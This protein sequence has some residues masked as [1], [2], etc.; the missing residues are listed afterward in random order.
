MPCGSSAF[1]SDGWAKAASDRL[2]PPSTSFSCSPCCLDDFAPKTAFIEGNFAVLIEGILNVGIFIGACGFRKMPMIARG[3]G[4]DRAGDEWSRRS[5][6]RKR[7]RDEARGRPP[8]Y[9]E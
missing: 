5:E 8:K 2:E 4:A 7:S 1:L 6:L 3:P 9:S